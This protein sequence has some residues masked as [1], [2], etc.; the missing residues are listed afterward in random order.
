MLAQ[1][2]MRDAG[3]GMGG[4]M[5]AQGLMPALPEERPGSPILGPPRRG[6]PVLGSLVEVVGTYP[7]GAHAVVTAVDR[8]A[9]TYKVRLMHDGSPTRRLRTIKSRHARLLCHAE[10]M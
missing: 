6:S 2:L 9:D 5:L 7:S 8:T 10:A 3:T 4:M 1:G